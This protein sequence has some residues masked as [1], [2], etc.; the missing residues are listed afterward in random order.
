[1]FLEDLKLEIKKKIYIIKTYIGTKGSG[2][3]Y[4]LINYKIILVMN[5]TRKPRIYYPGALYHIM[6]R[7]NNGEKVLDVK[8][9]K[10]KYLEILASYKKK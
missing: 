10:N 8:T 2:L 5:M 1:M 3:N 9:H 7:G 4:L 6:V